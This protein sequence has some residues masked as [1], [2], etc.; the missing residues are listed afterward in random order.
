VHYNSNRTGER[1]VGPKPEWARPDG[2]EAG[3]HPSNIHDVAYAIGSID[4]TGDM[5][6]LLGPDGPSLGGFVCPGVVARAELWKMGQLRPGDKVRLVPISPE[7]AEALELAQNQLIQSLGG[8]PA[9]AL[10]STVPEGAV[11]ATLPATPERVRVVY[12]RAGDRNLLVE[13]GP[14]ELDLRLRFRVHALMT[15]LQA[16]KL[17]GIVD[18]TPGVRS[19]QIH[20]DPHVL[21]SARLLSALQRAEQELPGIDAVEVPT[22]TVHLPLSWDDPQT[23]LAIQKYTTSVRPDAPWC[24]SNI[25]FIRRINGLPSVDDVYRTVFGASYLVLGLGDVYLGAPV[26]TPVDPRHR[27]VTTKYNPARTWT[28][29]NAVGI[30]GAYLCIYGMEGP[31]G[32]QFVGRTLQVYNRFRTTERFQPGSPWLLRFFDQIRFYPVSAA[33]LLEMREAF[34]YGKVDVKIESGTF[35]LREYEQFLA[36]NRESIASF[37][38][39]QQAAFDAERQRWIESGQLAF[40]SEAREAQAASGGAGELPAGAEA[41]E[42]HVPGSVWKLSVKAGE[43]VKRGQ[44]LL[45]VESMKMEIAVEA[46]SDGVVLELLVSEGRAVSPGQRVAVLGP[47]AT[48]GEV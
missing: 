34:P 42:A 36:D 31:G 11:P 2:G 7:Q 27:L 25:E 45:I 15:W 21:S 16:A 38:S 24:P 47:V 22:R 29:E 1:L 12:R 8:P 3:L 44:T 30:G 23:Q 39:Q 28:P 13:Y 9:A 19:L 10:V 32:Y 48:Q 33:D 46:A 17:P 4:F 26:A 41:V 14:L 20:F 35:K 18:L 40:S 37:K 6:I 5:P 43:R